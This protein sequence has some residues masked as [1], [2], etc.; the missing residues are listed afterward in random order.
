M[1]AE[2]QDRHARRPEQRGANVQPWRNVGN[3]G[4]VEGGFWQLFVSIACAER[5][6]GERFFLLAACAP[7]RCAREDAS[8]SSLVMV[9]LSFFLTAM[10]TEV[11]AALVREER[12]R[13][14]GTVNAEATPTPAASA[15]AR[16]EMS[17][18]EAGRQAKGEP[19]NEPKKRHRWSTGVT[20]SS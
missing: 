7:R 18:L 9:Y 12:G 16:R 10:L 13:A 1:S 19:E 14:V 2:E 20:Q 8:N 6:V 15:R 3:P 17:M 4:A 11:T 5:C